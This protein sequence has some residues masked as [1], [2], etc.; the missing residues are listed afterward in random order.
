MQAGGDNKKKKKKRKTIKFGKG[1]PGTKPMG[2][3]KEK[4]RKDKM[5][6]HMAD[7]KNKLDMVGDPFDN[8]DMKTKKMHA[9]SQYYTKLQARNDL[10]NPF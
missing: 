3:K 10:G 1:K 4:K 6:E 2:K 7:I 9:L 5:Q 8:M